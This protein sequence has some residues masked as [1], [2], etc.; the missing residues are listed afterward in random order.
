MS[1]NSIKNKMYSDVKN[2]QYLCD[3]NV[4]FL[5]GDFVETFY[6]LGPVNLESG[7]F[8]D[9]LIELNKNGFYTTNSQPYIS[10]PNNKQISYLEFYC[11]F[12]IAYKL[13]S[14]LLTD[15]EIFFSFHSS[16]N[17]K[18]VYIDTF[19]SKK[20]N[21]TKYIRDGEWFMYSNWHRDNMIGNDRMICDS[22]IV[23]LAEN[24]CTNDVYNLL[25]DSVC[26]MITGQEYRL[27]LCVVDK[28]IKMIEKLNL[29]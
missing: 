21:L 9:E 12:D 5:Q 24:Y 7:K 13:L 19:P 6:H 23:S 14:L 20:F 28:I 29:I 8:I 27:K 10:E 3:T 17:K 11:Q 18:L 26:I 1:I 4:K 25:S 2:C 22:E 15:D 16:S